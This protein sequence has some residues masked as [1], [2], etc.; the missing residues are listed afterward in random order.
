MKT[1]AL[2]LLICTV[3]LSYIEGNQACQ[4]WYTLC[5]IMLSVSSHFFLLH[6]SNKRV[7][8]QFSLWFSQEQTSGRSTFSF[9]GWPVSIFLKQVEYLLFSSHSVLTPVSTIP[10]NTCEGDKSNISINY[11]GNQSIKWPKV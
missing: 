8:R 7:P 5:K 10:F 1:S 4:A 3:V 11:L 2:P 9:P 6:T